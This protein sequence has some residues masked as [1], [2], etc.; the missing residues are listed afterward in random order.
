MKKKTY[1]LGTAVLLA[2]LLALAGVAQSAMWVGAEIGGNFVGS[3]K[4]EVN[5]LDF[6]SSNFSPS[7]IGGVTLGYDFVNTGFGAY[8]WPDWMKYFSVATDFTYN[9]LAMNS[10][11]DINSFGSVLPVNSRLNGYAAVWTFLVMAHYGFLPDSEVPGGRINPYIGVGPAIVFSGIDGTLPVPSR[12][13]P[14]TNSRFS[15]HSTNVALVVEPGIRWVAL[16]NVSID[17]AF[18]WRYCSPSWDAGDNVT[19]KANPLN[20]FSF[21]LRANYHF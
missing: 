12:A 17:T 8:A 21:L 15:A 9:R 5:G 2:A 13:A 7:V 19:V 4:I 10:S 16:K 20:Q 6:G 18:R 14:P 1:V 11:T 3:T